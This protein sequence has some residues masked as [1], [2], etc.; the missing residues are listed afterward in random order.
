LDWGGRGAGEFSDK[1]PGEK[2]E[3]QLSCEN[4]SV[5]VMNGGDGLYAESQKKDGNW[6]MREGCTGRAGMSFRCYRVAPG[7]QPKAWKLRG[8]RLGRGHKQVWYAGAC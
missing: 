3:G 1:P 2:H 5:G 6:L 4:I 8:T 7:G